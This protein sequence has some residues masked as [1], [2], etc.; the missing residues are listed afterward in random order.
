MKHRL[1]LRLKSPEKVS[2]DK[3]GLP[4]LDLWYKN[5][6]I[7]SLNVATY[8]DGDGDGVGDFKG[9]VEE[10]DHIAQLGVNCLWLLPFYPSPGLD[11]GY[12]VTDYYNVAPALGTLGDFVEFSHQ[13]RLR[14]MRL[15]I[16]LPINHTS[17]QHPWFQ[18]ARA[19]PQSAF[20]DYYVWSDTEPEDSTEGVVFPGVQLSVWTYD[21]CARALVLSPLL[22]APTRSEHCILCRSRRNLQNR[23]LLA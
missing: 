4:M 18:Q 14:G 17:E 10:L 19:D 15:I 5:A 1:R 11:H 6:A 16:D 12:D 13:A 2:V 3:A 22:P 8:K 9:L 7:Y 20:R 23:R 21:L